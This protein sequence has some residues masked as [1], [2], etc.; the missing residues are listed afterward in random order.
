MA[1]GRNGRD[2]E[3]YF[4]GMA[5]ES[6]FCAITEISWSLSTF[7]QGSTGRTAI[8]GFSVPDDYTTEDRSVEVL[9][10]AQRRCSVSRNPF[11][12]VVGSLCLAAMLKKRLS[13]LPDEAI[14]QLLLDH[15]WDGIDVFSPELAIC[16]VATERLLNS[17]S[18]FKAKKENVN[19]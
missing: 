12:R 3:K 16:Q 15:V 9:V 6:Q 14:G 10:E 17:S 1:R 2:F 5:R 18:V 11:A 8:R 13:V 7:F 19:Q 4:A